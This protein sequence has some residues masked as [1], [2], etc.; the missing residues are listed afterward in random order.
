MF[1]L[2]VAWFALLIIIGGT[3]L[4]NDHI[5]YL[6]YKHARKGHEKDWHEF[7]VPHKV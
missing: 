6:R 4:V 7:A 1:H 2:S 3:T 5:K